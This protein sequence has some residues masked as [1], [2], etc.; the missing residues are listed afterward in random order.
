MALITC[1]D[2]TLGYEGRAIVENLN[3]S[4]REGNYFCIVGENGS[5]K[6]TLMRTLLGLQQPLGGKITFGDGL[7][8]NQI[9][10]LPQQTLVQRDFPASV[11]EIV[12]SG[13]QGS[14]GIRPFY[15]KKEKQTAQEAMEKMDIVPLAKRCY[16]ELSGGQQQRVLLARAL[17]A[18][19]RVLLLD[20]PV[21]GLD[22]KVTAQMY[23][24]IKELNRKEKMTIIMISHDMQAAVTFASHILHVG[25]RWFFGTKKEY[26]KSDIGRVY[27][28]LEGGER[29]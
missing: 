8:Q 22:P 3:F 26:L 4:I 21:S 15:G 10:Y 14:C 24:L 9:G 20:E 7:V 19:D 18:A 27:S 6:S 23:N 5:G 11:R 12:L 25:H 16:R 1:Q 2:L 28:L 17:C 29:K 13:C